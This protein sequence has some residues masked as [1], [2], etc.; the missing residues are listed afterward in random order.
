MRIVFLIAGFTLTL[1]LSAQESRQELTASEIWQAGLPPIVQYGPSDYKA[2]PQNWSFVQDNNGIMYVG[3]TSGILEYDG[4]SWRLVPLPN[5]SPAKSFAKSDDGTVYV[6]G[7]RDFGYLQPDSTGR[8]RFRSLLNELDTT[9]HNFADI[10]FTYTI[11]N[12]AYFISDAYIFKWQQGDFKV[13]HAEEGFGFAS[14]VNKQL[15]IDKKGVGLMRMKND[16]LILIPDG[17]KF[18]D[19]KGSITI[20][21]PYAGNKIL[22]GHYFEGLFLYDH[23]TI[24]PFEEGA[25]PLRDR[26]VYSGLVLPSGHFV[27]T[28]NQGCFVVDDQGNVIQW[29]NKKSGLTSN[30]I[31]GCYADSEGSLWLATESGITRVEISSPL[32]LFGPLHGLTEITDRVVYFNGKLFAATKNGLFYLKETSADSERKSF[33]FLKVD[34]VDNQTWDVTTKHNYLLAGNFSGLYEV[35]AAHTV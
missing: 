30:V 23:Q 14:Q 19:D 11:D 9:Y 10:W 22:M 27:L 35:S 21:L 15:Y 26:H 7:V 24:S 13:W 1:T 6:G 18:V 3:N 32:R 16:S 12:A 29:L 33:Q 4:V 8:M 31:I 20:M 17:D 2:H 5:G 28:T 25:N 34:G